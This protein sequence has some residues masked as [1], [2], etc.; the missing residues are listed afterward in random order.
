METIRYFDLMKAFGY[1]E[2]VVKFFF[3]EKAYFTLYVRNMFRAT[4]LYKYHDR[5]QGYFLSLSIQNSGSGLGSQRA[6]SWPF[7]F[8]LCFKLIKIDI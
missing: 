8:S 2:N 6:L 4:T 5:A 7:L 3:S 1:I